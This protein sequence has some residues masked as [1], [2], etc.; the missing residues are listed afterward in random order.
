MKD[1]EVSLIQEEVLVDQ[2]VKSGLSDDPLCPVVNATQ[3]KLDLH[4]FCISDDWQSVKDLDGFP[5]SYGRD[6]STFENIY[7]FCEHV[8]Q[9]MFI[10]LSNGLQLIIVLAIILLML[11]LGPVGATIATLVQFLLMP[12]VAFGLGKLFKMDEIKMMT[13]I[14]LG[15]CPGGT[16]SNF[17]ALLLRGDMNLSILMTSV[18][19]VVG[20]GAIPIMIKALSSFV[21]DPCT[22]LTVDTVAIVKPLVLTLFPCAIGMVIKKYCKDKTCEII[23]KIGK[24]GMLVGLV[25]LVG[26]NIALYGS[27][28][29]KRFP[30]DI[31]IAISCVPWM[32]F[33]FGF[34][35][36]RLAREPPRSARTI[37]LETGLKNAQIC[38]IIMMMAFPPEKIGVLMMM[39]VYFLFFQCLESAVLAFIV[40]RYLASQDEETQE[41]LLEYAPGA[42]KAEFQRQV[43]TKIAKRT[44][45]PEGQVVEVRKERF[46][47]VLVTQDNRGDC[48]IS[49]MCGSCGKE[50]G[51]FRTLSCNTEDLEPQ[52]MNPISS[53]GHQMRL[54]STRSNDFEAA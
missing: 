22:D 33:V 24:I 38:L 5:D 3:D 10:K 46:E 32:G 18:S 20:V 16:L 48:S 15:C 34:V 25:A 45:T 17:M 27:S 9:P 1:I 13:M 53:P 28:L 11:G 26:I 43:S 7:I 30:V 52:K 41:K 4:A 50:A 47:N 31:L 37:M 39:P 2:V 51:N 14:V 40:T 23:I 49:F 44:F 12:V 54:A 8:N 35:F 29:V 21:V 42:E 6:N 36:A 19:T